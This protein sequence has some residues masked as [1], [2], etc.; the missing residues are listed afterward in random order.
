MIQAPQCVLTRMEV[1]IGKVW[2]GEEM[3]EEM[4]EP[5]CPRASSCKCVCVSSCVLLCCAH[6]EGVTAK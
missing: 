3:K 1:V 4:K 2:E 6:A 5:A